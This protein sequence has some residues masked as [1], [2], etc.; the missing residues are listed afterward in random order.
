MEDSCQLHAPA[1]L[2]HGKRPLYPLN[3]RLGGPRSRS[4]HSGEDKHFQPLPGLEPP[5]I[6]AVAQGYATKLSRLLF[7]LVNKRKLCISALYD[8]VFPLSFEFDFVSSESKLR[9]F[10]ADLNISK[11]KLISQFRSRV[12][13]GFNQLS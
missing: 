5:I 3:R 9:H 2:P 12:C 6:Q 7:I 4:G 11:V 8:F 1:A 13:C 10:T